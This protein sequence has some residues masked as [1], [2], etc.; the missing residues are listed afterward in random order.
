MDTFDYIVALITFASFLGLI[1]S[2]EDTKPEGKEIGETPNVINLTKNITVYFIVN[3]QTNPSESVSETLEPKIL[4]DWRSIPPKELVREV[5]EWCRGN[6][7]MGKQRRIRPNIRINNTTRGSVFGEYFYQSKTIE[8][9]YR[10]HNTLKK[11]V[12]TI[13]HEYV[14]HLQIRNHGDD[15]KYDT[16][17]RKVGYFDNP[18][19]EEA[20]M[21]AEKYREQCIRDL[22]IR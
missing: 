22:R 15:M 4:R 17:N 12:D 14:H 1:F 20:R 19:E 18:L 7:S 11:L 10:K 8:I 6:I 13:I 3:G 2:K 9:Y 21:I 16:L 5:V